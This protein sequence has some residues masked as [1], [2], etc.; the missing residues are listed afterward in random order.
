MNH[1]HARI[2]AGAVAGGIEICATYPLEFAKNSMQVQPG[3][4]SNFIHAMKF[5]VA[6][7]GPMILYRGLPSWLLF[8]FPRSWVRFGVYEN[9]I[10][11]FDHRL[12]QHA[13]IISGMISG[14]AEAFFCLVIDSPFPLPNTHI[15]YINIYPF[16]MREGADAKH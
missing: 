2:G 5:N 6:K 3:R 4:F 15:P 8:A 13:Q 16:V 14:A 12:D 9:V 1:R 10:E 7:D 11:I